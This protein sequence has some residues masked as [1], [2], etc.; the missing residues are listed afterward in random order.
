MYKTKLRKLNKNEFFTEDEISKLS[1]L[2]HKHQ[3]SL[4]IDPAYEIDDIISDLFCKCIEMK[5]TKFIFSTPYQCQYY[6]KILISI[7]NTVIKKS[8]RN[9]RY[10][11]LNCPTQDYHYINMYQGDIYRF[12]SHLIKIQEFDLYHFLLNLL[13]VYLN[14]EKTHITVSEL[15][16]KMNLSRRT[17]YRK[18]TKLRS[19]YGQTQ[20]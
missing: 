13:S 6:K 4:Q 20:L 8:K 10:L 19:I 11:T 7:C 18:I 3:N 9:V 1:F 5:N 14:E 12:A 15:S 17:Y 16:K 2:L